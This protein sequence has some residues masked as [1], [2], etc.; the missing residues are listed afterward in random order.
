MNDLLLLTT[1]WNIAFV[2]IVNR[3]D[4]HAGPFQAML[5]NKTQNKFRSANRQRISAQEAMIKLQRRQAQEAT[6]AVTEDLVK[7]GLYGL[8]QVA[9]IYSS[10]F[11]EDGSCMLRNVL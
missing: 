5:T 2:M 3:E 10:W 8:I 11:M 4:L 6:S 9:F 1:V 7:V